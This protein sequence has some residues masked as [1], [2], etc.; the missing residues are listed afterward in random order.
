VF[1]ESGT[2]V[3][4]EVAHFGA[5][6]E[7]ELSHVL[8]NLCLL[9]WGQC[10]EPLCKPNFSLSGNEQHII[11]LSTLDRCTLQQG[12]VQPW[13]RLVEQTWCGICD[14]GGSVALFDKF[15]N[16]SQRHHLR[17][18]RMDDE[19]EFVDAVEERDDDEL[20]DEGDGGEEHSNDGEGFGDDD[21]GDF[22][23]FEEQQVPHEAED[24]HDL[25]TEE[26]RQRNEGLRIQDSSPMHLPIEAEAPEIVPL[27]P[28]LPDLFARNSSTTR[29]NRENKSAMKSS[30]T[31]KNISPPTTIPPS[32]KSIP[33]Q[34]ND[35][36][37]KEPCRYGTNSPPRSHSTRQTG[38]AREF[39]ASSSSPSAS[40]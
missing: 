8:D 10:N 19:D 29:T 31:W 21:F 26:F 22:G 25:K 38:N 16:L 24:S 40:P 3:F 2:F 35:W 12:D 37:T 33:K 20:D 4:E 28:F 36:T 18:H 39:A 14:L 11:D 32:Q 9:L 23:D 30:S 34:Q 7:D 5:P 13:Q 27:L 6:G 15:G 1:G 17:G